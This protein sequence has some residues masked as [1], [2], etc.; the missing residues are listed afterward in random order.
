MKLI[1]VLGGLVVLAA[2]AS[3]LRAQS[4]GDLK[5]EESLRSAHIDVI[6][7]A[8]LF[9]LQLVE[10]PRNPSGT[11]V[12]PQ[13]M[14]DEYMAVSAAQELVAREQV[15][16]AEQPIHPP[17]FIVLAPLEVLSRSGYHGVFGNS[18][19]PCIYYTLLRTSPSCM[20]A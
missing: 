1:P 19:M 7:R 18:S 16:C 3:Q 12:V 14:L 10:E 5:D 8:I 6:K 4:C 17:Q 9:K 2:L 11:I 15:G 20:H 13:A